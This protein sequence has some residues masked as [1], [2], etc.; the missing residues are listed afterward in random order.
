MSRF[1]LAHGVSVNS[2]SSVFC[3]DPEYDFVADEKKNSVSDRTRG[4][5]RFT[6][7]NGV[8]NIFKFSIRYVSDQ[9][10]VVL[11]SWWINNTSLYLIDGVNSNYYPVKIMNSE[12]PID[13]LE[14]PYVNLWRGIIN[15]ESY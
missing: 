7:H 6:Y 11:N 2:I 14:H 12:P 3:V 4:G 15:L 5:D 10:K 9:D 8:F 1:Y 13:S